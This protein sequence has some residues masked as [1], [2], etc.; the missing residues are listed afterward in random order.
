VNTIKRYKKLR[1]AQKSLNTKLLDSLPD[2][3]KGGSLFLTAARELGYQVKGDTIVFPSE[4]AMD[5]LYEFLLYVPSKN[6]K[7]MAEKFLETEHDLTPDEEMI[8][9]KALESEPSLFRVAGANKQAAQVRL[10]D[11]LS[12]RPEVLI[13]DIHLSQTT[14]RGYLLFARILETPD[15]TFSSG[16]TMVFPEEDEPFLV[17]KCRQ[18]RRVKNPFLRAR[19]RFAFFAA[20][21]EQSRIDILYM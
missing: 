2:G 13:T 16:T 1:K 21:Q 4:A 17:K 6:G 5:R 10:H 14:R 7:S 12:K 18:F 20:M 9:R 15:V 11:L 19:K 3:A 8:L